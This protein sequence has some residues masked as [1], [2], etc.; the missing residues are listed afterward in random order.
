MIDAFIA[1]EDGSFKHHLQSED[2]HLTAIMAETIC[3]I[4]WSDLPNNRDSVTGE[5][6]MDDKPWYYD[7]DRPDVVKCD[8]CF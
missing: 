5:E 3:G 7:H 1:H 8:V 2:N 4:R 6:W